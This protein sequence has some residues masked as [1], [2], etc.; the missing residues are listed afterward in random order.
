MLVLDTTLCVKWHSE[1]LQVLCQGVQ[2]DGHDNADKP[3]RW[4]R[5]GTLLISLA[6]IQYM[7]NW[8]NM[9]IE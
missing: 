9:H 8:N 5:T 4:S 1:K 6:F 7:V 3:R 2:T